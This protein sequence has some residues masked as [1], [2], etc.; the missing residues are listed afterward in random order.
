MPY[1][2]DQA[3]DHYTIDA[4]NEQL[5][6]PEVLEDGKRTASGLAKSVKANQQ[7]KS[8]LDQVAGA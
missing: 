5:N 4:I 1:L 7:A 8:N 3:V 2:I 6:S